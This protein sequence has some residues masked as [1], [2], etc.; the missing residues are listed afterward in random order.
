M[1]RMK[2]WVV[3]LAI[4]LAAGMAGAQ[5][6]DTSWTRLYTGVPFSY[7]SGVATDDS[8]NVYVAGYVDQWEYDALVLR[9]SP[10]G[11]LDWSGT[12]DD[13]VA[14]SDEYINGCAWSPDGHLYCVGAIVNNHTNGIDGLL[15]KYGRGGTLEWARTYSAPQ[16][17]TDWLH[18]ACVMADGS[19]FVC[20]ETFVDSGSDLLAMKYTADG[21]TV[22]V[23]RWGTT[24]NDFGNDCALA[25]D[26]SLYVAGS[27]YNGS[28]NDALLVKFSSAGDTVWSRRYTGADNCQQ[29]AWGCVCDGQ[30]NVLV[31]GT[32]QDPAYATPVAFTA[33][34]ASD[35]MQQWLRKSAASYAIGNDGVTVAI[36]TAGDVYT[37]G[38]T[39][40]ASRDIFIQKYSSSGDSLWYTSL[41]TGV[42][43]EAPYDCCIDPAGHLVLAGWASFA[44]SIG[45]YT[46]KYG[47]LCGVSGRPPSLLQAEV[48]LRAVPNPARQSVRFCL[49]SQQIFGASARFYDMT[50]R[51]VR[52]IEYDGAALCWDLKDDRGRRVPSGV[53][54]CRI[55]DAAATRYTA[56]AVV[57]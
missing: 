36:D 32:A 29:E 31:T 7:G 2:H 52:R 21:D 30:G 42:G 43:N 53:Y 44:K 10:G 56:F 41:D 18:D 38:E 12:Y 28:D 49:D 16:Y 34:Y 57:R 15:L 33:K 54:L 20:G 14:N 46:V 27:T 40:G 39:Y 11:S 19:L 13:S 51:M 22:W 50:G 45:C 47:Q 4:A 35:G 17:G 26:G 24:K 23:R 3:S 5:A 48:T 25:P 37:C 55:D 1:I 8:C 9:Y 6:P